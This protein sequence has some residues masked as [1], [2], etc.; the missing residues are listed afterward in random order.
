MDDAGSTSSSQYGED[1]L[2]RAIG[3]KD[4]RGWVKA[5]GKSGVGVGAQKAFGKAPKALSGPSFEDRA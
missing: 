3:K 5:L 1:V 4:H 2:T